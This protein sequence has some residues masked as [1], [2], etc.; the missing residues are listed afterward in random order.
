MVDKLAFKS[1]VVEIQRFLRS[2]GRFL[3]SIKWPCA[4]PLVTSMNLAVSPAGIPP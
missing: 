4:G 3:K 1:F 2:K